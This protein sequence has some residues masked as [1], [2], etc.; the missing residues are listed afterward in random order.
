MPPRSVD[1]RSGELVQGLTLAMALWLSRLV[2][3]R[4]GVSLYAGIHLV[5]KD[6][7]K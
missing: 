3:T 5:F 2:E 4:R 7:L 6:D 1:V